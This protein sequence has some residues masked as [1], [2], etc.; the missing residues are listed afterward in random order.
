MSD[1]DN[2]AEKPRLRPVPRSTDEAS[3]SRPEIRSAEGLRRV[4]RVE[5]ARP[6]PPEPEPRQ[7]PQPAPRQT[8]RAAPSPSSGA[9]APTST[10][11]G[12]VRTAGLQPQGRQIQPKATARRTAQWLAGKLLTVVEVVTIIALVVVVILSL[13]NLATLNEEA[14][15][16]QRLLLTP[17][18]VSQ[19]GALA[20]RAVLP[21]SSQPPPG[22]EEIPPQFRPYLMPSTP[23]PLPT[24]G[25]RQG[26]RIVIKKIKVDAPVL[27]GDDW[28]TLKKGVGHSPGTANPG[29]AGNCVLSGHDDVYGEVFRYLS[30]LE[31]GDEVVV[32]TSDGHGF[33]YVVKTKFLVEPDAVEVMD[34]TAD[35]VL[36][37]ITCYPYLIDTHRLIVVCTLTGDAPAG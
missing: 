32:Y 10:T 25:P 6:A 24:P 27:E 29:E 4:F 5:P 15:A 31:P 3:S 20:H 28:H 21:G 33:Q 8:R 17:T 30:D 1:Q 9:D 26:T 22:E 23:V 13:T 14:A 11:L 16:E 36:T 34:P 35:S 37:L 2:K 19:A 18:A 7:A 12:G